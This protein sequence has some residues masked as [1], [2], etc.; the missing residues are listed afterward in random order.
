M[1]KI[2]LVLAVLAVS[3]ASAQVKTRTLE[4]IQSVTQ[5]KLINN[6][7]YTLEC[8]QMS[9]GYCANNSVSPKAHLQLLPDPGSTLI[10]GHLMIIDPKT[11]GHYIDNVILVLKKVD[12]KWQ[13]TLYSL[14]DDFSLNSLYTN[15]NN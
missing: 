5:V 2:I 1:K 8:V 12:Q 11:T 9:G 4:F 10:R 3:T 6:S 14:Y 7:H 15:P 13:L